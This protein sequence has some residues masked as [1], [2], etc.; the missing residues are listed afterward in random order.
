MAS[1]RQIRAN[2]QNSTLSTGPSE[3]GKLE[4]RTNGFIDGLTSEV[5]FSEDQVERIEMRMIEWQPEIKAVG[6]LQLE[7]LKFMAAASV[8]IDMCLDDESDWRYRQACRPESVRILHQKIEVEEVAEGLSRRPAKIALK[9]QDTKVG[10][11][12]LLDHLRALDDLIRGNEADGPLHPLEE[13]NRN[14]A[15][16]LLGVIPERRQVRTLLDPPAPAGAEKP[17]DATVAAHQAGVIAAEIA[18]LETY[19]IE[20][21]TNLEEIDREAN[22]L[23]RQIKPDPEIRRIRRCEAAARRAY[24]RAF[25]EL[26]RLQGLAAEAARIAEEARYDR[27]T[28]VPELAEAEVAAAPP[29]AAAVVA[30]APDDYFESAM[31]AAFPAPDSHPRRDDKKKGNAARAAHRGFPPEA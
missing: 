16:D 23:G 18:R 17:S 9:L 11:D 6:P 10:C 19:R 31:R 28:A 26:V 4:S 24:D 22:A 3:L 7:Q 25:A 1:L 27:L 12:W 15:F 20:G 29:A 5:V 14:L 2:Q 13:A 21:L 30:P 8:R